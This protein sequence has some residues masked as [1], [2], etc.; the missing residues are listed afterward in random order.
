MFKF[1]TFILILT[2][3]SVSAVWFIENDGSIVVEWMGYRIQT[4]VMFTV[5]SIVVLFFLLF[6][7]LQVLSAIKNA[8]K[9]YQKSVKDKKKEKGLIALTEGFA[10]IAAGDVKQA[11]KLTK[12]AVGC[13]GNA[14]VTKLLAAQSAQLEGN[15]GEAKV[16]YSA[17]LENKETEMIAIKG[18]LLQAEKDGD[19]EEAITLAGKAIQAQPN[20]DWANK[21]LLRLYKI[22]K[23][24]REARNLTER[25]AKLKLIT[26]EQ[27]K[28]DIAVMDVALSIE[29]KE[30][31]NIQ[32]AIE[33]AQKACKELT[34]FPPSAVIYAKL[35][36]EANK[37]N[38]RKAVNVLEKC[39][40]IN[41]NPLIADEYMEIY[42]GE[43]PEKRL[44]YAERLLKLK[45]NDVN[46]H[47]IVAKAAIAADNTSK[48]RN[49]LKVSL[50]I[51]ETA[52]ICLLM[53]EVERI[54][55]ADDEAVKKW[56]SRAKICPPDTGWHCKKCSAS[57]TIWNANCDNC[58]SFDSLKWSDNKSAINILTP[59]EQ[60]SIES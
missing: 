57:Q 20:S 45:P 32:T 60:L 26:K 23:R 51:K 56:V 2:L 35:L 44:K 33:Y 31:G 54:E 49:H 3:I 38:K 12:Q 22:T 29:A 37:N 6:V 13:L 10:A 52:Q 1:L 58:G 8:P 24:W 55:E 9:N 36:V 47:I 7:I 11:K 46:S 15:F 27:A 39:W 48:A 18:L 17:M 34:G 19:T 16:H 50:N 59:K 30:K 5:F 43:T 41:P 25:A 28:R 4:S 40:K 21:V 53:A 42:S 14:P